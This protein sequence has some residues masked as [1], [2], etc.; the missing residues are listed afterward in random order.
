MSS[1]WCPARSESVER[2]SRAGCREL[3]LLFKTSVGAV[4]ARWAGRGKQGRG[5]RLALVAEGHCCIC[6]FPLQ[7]VTSWA[8]LHVG[9]PPQV[10]PGIRK[11]EN[12]ARLQS[13]LL[14]SGS[15]EGAEAVASGLGACFPICEM[16]GVKGQRNRAYFFSCKGC[17]VAKIEHRALLLGG[18]YW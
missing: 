17:F 15:C 8:G 16:G 14:A 1:P 7:T 10:P 18:C 6:P 4:L 13:A 2:A 9:W 11:R 12:W 5:V 3:Q